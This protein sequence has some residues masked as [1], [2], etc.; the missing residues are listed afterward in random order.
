[1]T[2]PPSSFVT[3]TRPEPT[4][5]SPKF[6]KTIWWFKP[7]PPSIPQQPQQTL[8]H[9]CHCPSMSIA[10]LVITKVTLDVVPP[11]HSLL[12]RLEKSLMWI[13]TTLLPQEIPWIENNVNNVPSLSFLCL[14]HVS[15]LSVL[16]L[17]GLFC[18]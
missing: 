10:R 13:L 1:M 15:C 12:S 9:P 2:L 4:F 3:L 5:L 17:I 14:F 16:L 18:G 6:T 8:P 7:Q 11:Q